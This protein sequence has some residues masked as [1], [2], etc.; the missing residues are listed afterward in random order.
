MI[1]LKDETLLR[2]SKVPEWCEQNLGLSVN[3]STVFRWRTRGIGGVKLE[4][5]RFGGWRWTS[6][7]ALQRFFAASNAPDCREYD[8]NEAPKAN[9]KSLAKAEK[10]LDA[11]GL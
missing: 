4:T 11:E 6:E 2:T 3:R 5:C 7:E 8:S 9:A 10:F 1:K